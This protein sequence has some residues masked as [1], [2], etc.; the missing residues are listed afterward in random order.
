MNPNIKRPTLYF[1]T[2]EDITG[3]HHGLN[4]VVYNY[5]LPLNERMDKFVE[6]MESECNHHFTPDEIETLKSF[7]QYQAYD[8]IKKVREYIYPYIQPSE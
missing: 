6:V 4:K 2:L 1:I 7:S 8:F 5:I 3:N